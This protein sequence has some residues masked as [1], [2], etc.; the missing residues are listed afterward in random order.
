MLLT[1]VL[2]SVLLFFLGY[3]SVHY[4]LSSWEVKRTVAIVSGVVVGILVALFA[5]LTVSA[6]VSL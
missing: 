5:S 1:I 6:L 3:S 2:S 4:T